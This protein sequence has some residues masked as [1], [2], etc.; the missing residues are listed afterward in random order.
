MK[1]K[2]LKLILNGVLG[3]MLGLIFSKHFPEGIFDLR[4]WLG[5]I[6]SCSIVHTYH[7]IA[8]FL[9]EREGREKNH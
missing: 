9:D 7:F 2:K 4:W 6:M 1:A 3:A 5:V 8:T